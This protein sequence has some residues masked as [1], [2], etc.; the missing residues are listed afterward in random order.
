MTRQ[1]WNSSSFDLLTECTFSNINLSQIIIILTEGASSDVSRETIA[2][3]VLPGEEEPVIDL[4]KPHSISEEELLECN[5]ESSCSGKMH[6]MEKPT[7]NHHQAP[8]RPISCFD[9]QRS[10]C[11]ENITIR[12]ISENLSLSQ[13][14]EKFESLPSF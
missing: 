5:F 9:P 4:S 6:D 13:L 10:T 11:N 7:T 8:S 1:C 12:S 2:Q 14:S 3:L